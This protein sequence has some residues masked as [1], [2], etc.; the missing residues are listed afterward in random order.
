MPLNEI[1]QKLVEDN[2]GLVGTVIKENVRNVNNLGIFTYQDIFQIG[3]V[4]LTKSAMNYKP[5]KD[6]FSTCAYIYIRNEIFNAL[7]YA[8]VRRRNEEITDPEIVHGLIPAQDEFEDNS[9]ELDKMLEAA[10]SRA[11]GVIA[12]GIDAIRLMADG[13]T[14]REIGELMGGVSANNITAWISKARAFLKDDPDITAFRD[15]V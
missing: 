13:Y 14:C 8:T 9:S 10:K 11:T 12:K 6:K 4:G 7:D 15:A 5:G 2:M 3:C 1:Q